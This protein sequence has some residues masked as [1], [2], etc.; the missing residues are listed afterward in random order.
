MF[1]EWQL[2][3]HQVT[4]WCCWTNVEWLAN[5]QTAGFTINQLFFGI[6]I[7]QFMLQICSNT[8]MLE[9]VL[10]LWIMDIISPGDTSTMWTFSANIG[11]RLSHC[12]S[13]LT[14]QLIWIEASIYHMV[15]STTLALLQCILVTANLPDCIGTGAVQ[16][17]NCPICRW[18]KYLKGILTG[19][20][21]YM[22][23]SKLVW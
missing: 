14:S 21:N 8:P 17:L 9:Q 23:I 20:R 22:D 6:S 11:Q 18:M 3:A 2:A 5:L 15:K 13:Q 1:P 19:L 12:T 10:H 16:T 4:M 7:P